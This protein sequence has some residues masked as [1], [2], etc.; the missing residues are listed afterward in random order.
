M[1]SYHYTQSGLDNVWLENGFLIME[2]PYG[3][4]V[5]VDDVDGLHRAIGAAL[6]EKPGTLTGKEFRFL[7]LELDLSQV[8]L[9]ELLGTS[10]QSVARWE[11][12][13]NIPKDVDF[14]VRHIYRQEVLRSRDT[15]VQTVDALKAKDKESYV[16]S[17]AFKEEDAL[18]RRAG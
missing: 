10:S 18:W 17:I 16:E 3:R 15:Y 5:A 11:K 6:V 13:G 14:L 12:T 7:R 8:R 1:N 2:T 9:G 4:S